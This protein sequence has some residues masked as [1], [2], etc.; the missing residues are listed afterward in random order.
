MNAY[1]WFDLYS[2]VFYVFL[3]MV[4]NTEWTKTKES[5]DWYKNIRRLSGWI[6]LKNLWNDIIYIVLYTF[7]AIAISN[8]MTSVT[9]NTPT[10]DAT[11]AL[12]GINLLLLKLWR[13]LLYVPY[14]FY[15]SKVTGPE[16][17]KYHKLF[18]FLVFD[19][20]LLVATSL[21]VVTE[22]A[23]ARIWSSFGLYFVY[24]LW[25]LYLMIA[26]FTIMIFTNMD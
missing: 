10:Y 8:Y 3:F 5:D 24:C 2:I 18:I 11:L 23:Y 15:N 12:W 21:Y 22:F 6:V 7:M 9:S 26:S 14:M 4:I 19:S 16:K 25:N 17:I 13:Y 20:V 1:E